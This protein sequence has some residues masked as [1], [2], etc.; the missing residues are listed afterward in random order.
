MGAKSVKI[1]RNASFL[2]P[3]SSAEPEQRSLILG[4][5]HQWVNKEIPENPLCSLCYLRSESAQRGG[6]AG[7]AAGGFY[8]HHIKLSASEKR[9]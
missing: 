9:V 6:Q 1:K 3:R 5:G 4:Y 8:R 7:R 2:Q